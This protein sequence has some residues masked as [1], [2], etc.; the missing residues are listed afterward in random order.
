MTSIVSGIVSDFRPFRAP[1]LRIPDSA[2]ATR[3]ADKILHILEQL[4]D[5]GLRG[6]LDTTAGR[7]LF[8][9]E[10]RAEALIAEAQRSDCAAEAT[11]LA[12]E[13]YRVDPRTPASGGSVQLA[14]AALHWQAGKE[15]ATRAWLLSDNAHRHADAGLWTMAREQFKAAGALDPVLAWSIN[16]A[17]WMTATSADPAA[18]DGD[19][20]VAM[21]AAACK[22]RG[23]GNASMLDTLAAAYALRGDFVRAVSWQQV[24]LRLCRV[25]SPGEAEAAQERLAQLRDGHPITGDAPADASSAELAALA[26]VAHALEAPF[27]TRRDLIDAVAGVEDAGL[28][29]ARWGSPLRWSLDMFLDNFDAGTARRI[30][31][32]LADPRV[33]G[34]ICYR[35]LGPEGEPAGPAAAMFFGAELSLCEAQAAIDH[36]VRGPDGDVLPPIGLYRRMRDATAAPTSPSVH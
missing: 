21:A 17:A 14:R 8:A 13:A 31:D 5:T 32:R 29:H 7:I 35:D 18:H 10:A 9:D 15:G 25:Q 4:P 3:G 2:T 6:T 34:A 33:E 19:F 26:R 24:A 36:E 1:C 23:W 27:D 20:A 12:D 16:D 11:R 28:F 22:V 30:L